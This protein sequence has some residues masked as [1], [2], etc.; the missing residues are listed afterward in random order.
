MKNTKTF[1]NS[2]MR[3]FFLV[4]VRKLLCV[5]WMFKNIISFYTRNKKILP[6]KPDK[7]TVVEYYKTLK[8]I[9]YLFYIDPK[10]LN[11]L[12]ILCAIETPI[13]Q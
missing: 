9:A 12:I 1:E 2:R 4:K 13:M 7:I 6:I 10:V 11:I 8:P 3:T 5:W